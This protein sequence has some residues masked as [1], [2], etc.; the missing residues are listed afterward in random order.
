MAFAEAAAAASEPQSSFAAA[1]LRKCLWQKEQQQSFAVDSILVGEMVP[2]AGAAQQHRRRRDFGGASSEATPRSRTQRMVPAVSS[3]E[4]SVRATASDIFNGSEGATSEGQGH[5]A[6]DSVD[7]APVAAGVA[8]SECEEA[9]EPKSTELQSLNQETAAAHSSS[10]SSST[11]SSRSSSASRPAD[12]PSGSP[13]SA[14]MC[15][16]ATRLFF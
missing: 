4:L 12:N 8:S 6:G 2:T 15:P 13:R 14:F 5:A 16:F 1:T 11:A 3:S 9:E 7:A 10:S